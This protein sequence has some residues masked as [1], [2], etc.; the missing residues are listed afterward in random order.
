MPFAAGYGYGF[1]LPTAA[2]AT[3]PARAPAVAP[4]YV[5]SI[6]NRILFFRAYALTHF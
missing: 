4:L 5:L 3:A 6:I 1:N 2:P